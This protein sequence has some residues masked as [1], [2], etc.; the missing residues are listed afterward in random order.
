M[1]YVGTARYVTHCAAVE[2]KTV[3]LAAPHSSL[4]RCLSI[5]T[6]VWSSPASGKGYGGGEGGK[7]QWKMT[8]GS[9]N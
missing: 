6:V 1:Q 5:P 7:A 2:G 9:R 8:R 3:L 4:N